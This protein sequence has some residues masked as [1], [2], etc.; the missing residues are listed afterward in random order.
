MKKLIPFAALSLAL[1]AVA[2]CGGSSDEATVTIAGAA[3]W[4][5]A[6]FFFASTSHCSYFAFDTACTAIGM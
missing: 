3:G 4:S 1:V 6:N 2:G 5:T